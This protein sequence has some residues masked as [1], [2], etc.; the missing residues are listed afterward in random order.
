MIYFLTPLVK[1]HFIFFAWILTGNMKLLAIRSSHITTK[2][3]SM[4]IKSINLVWVSV[5]DFKGSVKFYKDV[6]GLK[7]N[8][9]N[10]EY[11]WAEF[12]GQEGGALLGIGVP[13]IK[14]FVQPGQNA[15]VTFTVDD[16]VKTKEE[17]GKK[18]VKMLGEIEEVPGI[19]KM[20]TFVDDNG[21]HAQLVQILDE[22]K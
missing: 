20:Q 13:R 8:E 5:K 18:G 21:N 4:A 11:N 2:E 6:L 9:I 14:D 12:S 22:K 10:E 15:V 19:V 1:S 7:L 17:L 16:I 3:L